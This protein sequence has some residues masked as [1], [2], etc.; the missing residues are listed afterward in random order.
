MSGR[1]PDPSPQ[2]A[3][4]A[5]AATADHAP[6]P[7]QSGAATDRLEALLAEHREP[8]TEEPEEREPSPLD[9]FGDMLRTT[10]TETVARAG[11]GGEEG[12][13]DEEDHGPSL[14]DAP[15][16][17]LLRNIEQ[18]VG[19]DRID[20]I[21]VFPP[22]RLEAGETSVVV[23]AAFPEVE[24]DRRRVYAAHYTTREETAEPRLALDEYGTAPTERVGRLV[25]EVVERI[26]DGPAGAPRSH[27]IEGRDDRWATVLH[28][29]AEAFL[30]E[31]QKNPRL[32]R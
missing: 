24:A 1:R 10:S 31:I 29:L 21:W 18:D 8:A 4:S 25:E 32:R 19:I 30:A 16:F 11:Q 13:P 22:R 20:R 3:D 14:P 27:H 9:P 28:E 5:E 17:A 6:D 2:P 26:K 23:V 15:L 12:E 7:D